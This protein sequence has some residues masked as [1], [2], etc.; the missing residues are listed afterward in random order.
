MNDFISM[1]EA[2]AFS[3]AGPIPKPPEGQIAVPLETVDQYLHGIILV[4]NG[5]PPTDYSEMMY[6]FQNTFRPDAKA[7]AG[8]DVLFEV[9]SE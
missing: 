8:G 6:R 4:N 3:R 5:V 7:P 9:K 1:R 2:L